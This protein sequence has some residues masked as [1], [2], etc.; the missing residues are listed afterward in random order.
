[1]NVFTSILLLVFSILIIVACFLISDRITSDKPNK[2]DDL[3]FFDWLR[4]VFLGIFLFIM[5][6]LGAMAYFGALVLTPAVTKLVLSFMLLMIV[7]NVT[8]FTISGIIND[9]SLTDLEKI[10]KLNGIVFYCGTIA[11]IGMG[12][13]AS[14]IWRPL[15]LGT[16]MIF[17]LI[18]WS[19]FNSNL[20]M[21]QS[22]CSLAFTRQSLYGS[23]LSG[24]VIG[25]AISY[26][27]SSMSTSQKNTQAFGSSDKEKIFS[28][29][30]SKSIGKSFSLP[31]GSSNVSSVA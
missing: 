27:V 5:A 13:I 6:I 25:S 7:C 22:K 31:K 18:L 29:S 17:A 8:C 14:Q 2:Y 30:K 26:L 24:L 20:S 28:L 23:I 11:A 9:S 16:M 19:G 12:F 21:E 15:I 1:M 10:S 4:W 3:K